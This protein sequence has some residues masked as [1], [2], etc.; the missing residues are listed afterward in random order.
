MKYLPCLL[1]ATVLFPLC[2]GTTTADT[3]ECNPRRVWDAMINAKGGRE[4]LHQIKTIYIE[5]TQTWWRL[6]RRHRLQRLV[7]Y[8]LPD[9]QWSWFDPGS[10]MFPV[11]VSRWNLQTRSGT[12]DPPPRDTQTGYRGNLRHAFLL[13]DQIVYLFETEWLKPQPVACRAVSAGQRLEV[14]VNDMRYIYDVPDETFL[15][16]KVVEIGDVDSIE[17]QLGD[18]TKVD[19][20]MMPRWHLRRFRRLAPMNLKVEFE[21]N[22][23]YDRGILAAQPSL[24]AGPRAWRAKK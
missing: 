5:E 11:S 24:A 2:V 16:T 1:H 10:D 7:F 13:T 23:S 15:P 8:R 6:L 21:I 12:S 9:F 14:T 22:P 20:L 18:Y 17:H 3:A 19:G 4:R